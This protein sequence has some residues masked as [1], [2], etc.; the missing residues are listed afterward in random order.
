MPCT[1]VIDKQRRLV[2]TKAWGLVTAAEVI[3][4]QTQL[5]GDADFDRTFFQ[6][7][8]ASGV[9]K[10]DHDQRDV[11]LLAARE[12]FSAESRR[13]FVAGNEVVFG[14]GRMFEIY[15]ELSGVGEQVRI[16]QDMNAALQWLGLRAV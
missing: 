1:Y 8:D 16:F 2:L 11:Q 4:H 15:R 14:I 12:M 9:T 3:A 13:A 7:F 5:R 6:L 10:L